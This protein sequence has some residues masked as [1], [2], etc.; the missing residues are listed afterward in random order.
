MRVHCCHLLSFLHNY[1]IIAADVASTLLYVLAT[2]AA[3]I[4][5]WKVT[6]GELAVL[7]HVVSLSSRGVKEA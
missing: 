1:Y 6:M 5:V 3:V 4:V 2:V 7:R